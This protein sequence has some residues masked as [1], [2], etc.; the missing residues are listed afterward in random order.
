VLRGWLDRAAI[1][2]ALGLSEH[3][4]VLLAQTIGYAQ[5]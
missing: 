2:K 1:A 3:E 5:S 4:H